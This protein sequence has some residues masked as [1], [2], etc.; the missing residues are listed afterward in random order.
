MGLGI[1]GVAGWLPLPEPSMTADMVVQHFVDHQTRIRIGMTILVISSVLWLAFSSVIATQMKRIEGEHHPLTYLQLLSAFGTVL[2]IMIP[3]YLWLAMAYRPE[4]T[5]AAVMQFVNDFNWFSFVA[6]FPPAVIQ[7]VAIASCTLQDKR[8]Q[9]I[10][11]RWFGFA[12]L[13]IAVLFLP[14]ALV[15]FFKHGPFAW[16][17]LISFWLVATVFFGWIYLLWWATRR[18]I[19]RQAVGG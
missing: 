1:F 9:P 4:Q 13:W 17:G 11:P 19:L 6:M 2:P 8:P 5:P 10:F 16:N 3:G 12:N 14:G 7:A 18:A 15:P